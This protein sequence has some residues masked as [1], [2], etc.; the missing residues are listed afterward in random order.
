MKKILLTLAIL[1]TL[2]TVLTGCREKKSPEEKIEEAIEDTGD[3]IE[4]AADE[5]ADEIEDATE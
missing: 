4:D 2:S 3:A 1:F 5:V